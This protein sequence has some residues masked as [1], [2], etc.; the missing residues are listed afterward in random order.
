MVPCQLGATRCL[1]RQHGDLLEFNPRL[2]QYLSLTGG[3]GVYIAFLVLY[4][5]PYR[6]IFYVLRPVYT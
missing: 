2:T 1:G 5:R 6:V 4:L 3:P